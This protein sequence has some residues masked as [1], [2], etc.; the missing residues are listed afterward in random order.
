MLYIKCIVCYT[1]IR[2][3]KGVDVMQVNLK[4]VRTKHKLSQEKLAEL[5][6]VSRV[7]IANIECG[8]TKEAKIS[9]LL[10]L[11]KA[12]NVSLTS[13]FKKDV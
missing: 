4:E 3:G 9:T 13:F 2:K 8:K 7:T 12:L 6:G 5:S 10:S 1:S 11:A